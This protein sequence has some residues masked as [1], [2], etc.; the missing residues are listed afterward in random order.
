MLI[1]YI[2]LLVKILYFWNL[3]QNQQLFPY[4]LLFS[5][6][7]IQLLSNYLFVLSRKLRALYVPPQLTF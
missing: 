3:G 2:K 1:A 7:V 4:F 6:N 5:S